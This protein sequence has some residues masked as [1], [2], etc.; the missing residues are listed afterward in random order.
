MSAIKIGFIGYGGS[1]RFFHLPYILPNPDLEVYAF[2]QRSEAPSD[3]S[4]AKS[5]T[6]CTINFPNAKHYQT[7]EDFFADPAIELVI[8]CTHTG[9]HSE[10]AERALRAGK[11]VVVEKPFTTSSEEAD[12]LIAISKETGKLLTVFQNRRYDGD[13]MTLKHLLA[14]DALGTITEAEIHYDFENP[15][16]LHFMS[17]KKYTPG[18]GMMFGLGSHS[19]DQ[20]LSLFGKPKSVTAFLRDL[21]AADSEVEDTFTIILQYDS[22]LLVTIKTTITT[23]M[24]EQLHYLVRGTKGSYIK[25]GT[26]AQEAHSIAGMASDDPKFGVEDASLHGL[27]TTY[28]EF[29]KSQSYDSERKKYIGRYPTITGR[30]RGYYEDLVDAIRGKAPLQVEAQQSREGIRVMELARKSHE[31]GATVPWE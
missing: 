5:G 21:R 20:A 18:D 1:A 27:L 4:V 24:E 26:D 16:W 19:I 11:H 14:K 23:C 10:F 12:R 25:H 30:I 7:A 22:P 9:T 2:L 28:A 3:P 13:F 31:T 8:V 15:S 17:A 6:H 29:D